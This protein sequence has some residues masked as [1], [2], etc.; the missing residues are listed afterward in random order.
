MLSTI[1]W[2]GSTSWMPPQACPKSC[3]NRSCI[4]H[5]ASG[6]LSVLTGILPVCTSSR[7]SPALFCSLQL[8]VSRP[9]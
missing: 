5:S 1:C 9:I 8:F 2:A 3:G 7:M 6:R 4:D